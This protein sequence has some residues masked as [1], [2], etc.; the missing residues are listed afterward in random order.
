MSETQ[1]IPPASF[2]LRTL[3]AFLM[4]AVTF[5]VYAALVLPLSLRPAA[6]PLQA[7]DVAPRDMQATRDLEYVSQVRTD[8]AREAAERNVL[9]VYTA[10]DPGVAREQIRLMKD[11][12]DRI[13]L[14][15]VDQTVTI[16]QRETTISAV[17]PPG[18][19]D[20]KRAAHHRYDRGALEHAPAGGRA[21]P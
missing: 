7:G 4:I 11:S 20:R 16:E 5:V 9:P 18:I 17:T 2:S 3:R 10:P 6:P 21:R 8:E 12:L 15:R 1:K 19:G 14:L 13:S